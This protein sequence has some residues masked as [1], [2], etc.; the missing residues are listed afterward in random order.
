MFQLIDFRM[1][2]PQGRGR[3]IRNTTA[4]QCLLNIF[5]KS[6]TIELSSLVLD[7]I[8]NIYQKDEA[9]YFILES[10]NVLLY[11]LDDFS[12][13]IHLKSRDLQLKF[14]DIIEYI[15]YSLKFVPC[16]ELV[17]IGL[18]IQNS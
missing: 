2:Q 11:N 1:P 8:K 3:T 6:K 16:K 4:F 14:I 12:I 10:Q 9:N 7:S 17:S 13:K 15:I 18:A 5:N